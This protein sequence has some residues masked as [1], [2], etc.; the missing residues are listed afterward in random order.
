MRALLE[1]LFENEYRIVGLDALVSNCLRWSLCTVS[2]G[3]AGSLFENEYR[4]VGLD[5]LASDC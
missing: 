3:V 2:A 4:I 5:A 1:R